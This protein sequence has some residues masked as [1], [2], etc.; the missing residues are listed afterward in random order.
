[1]SGGGCPFV[2]DDKNDSIFSESIHDSNIIDW[3]LIRSD[4]YRF[5]HAT[6]I[7]A[8]NKNCHIVRSLTMMDFYDDATIQ[9]TVK[10]RL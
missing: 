1:L 9:S 7:N 2:V 4:N 3:I 10:T 6:R 8:K 5:P